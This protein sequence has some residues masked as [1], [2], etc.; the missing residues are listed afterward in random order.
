[1]RDWW[2]LHLDH[3][4]VYIAQDA[5]AVYVFAPHNLDVMPMWFEKL[6]NVAMI[7]SQPKI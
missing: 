5:R 6:F 1:V 4:A 7:P 2:D 3:A